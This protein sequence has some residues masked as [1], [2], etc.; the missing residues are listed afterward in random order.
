MNRKNLE[1]II[2]M[3]WVVQNLV[4]HWI[5]SYPYKT[6]SAQETQRS[7]RHFQS[8]AEIPRCI[9][10]DISLELLKAFEGADLES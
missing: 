9:Y 7:L 1:C 3:Q 2:N 10:T 4:I 8:T 6:K 5:Q